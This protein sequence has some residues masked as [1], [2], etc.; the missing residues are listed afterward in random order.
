[1]SNTNNTTI[2]PIVATFFR[3]LCKALKNPSLALYYIKRKLIPSKK[4]IHLKSIFDCDFYQNNKDI[5]DYTKY[6]GL[7]IDE[8]KSKDLEYNVMAAYVKSGS[9]VIDI[10]ANIGF[11]T[12]GLSKL[13]GMSGFVYAFEPGPISFSI[14]SRNI[15]ANSQI[16]GDNVILNKMAISDR[17]GKSNLFINTSGE[18][19][20]Q[21][22]HDT[23]CY[24]FNSEPPR[25]KIITDVTTLDSYFKNYEKDKISFIKCD[26]QGHEYYVLLGSPNLFKRYRNAD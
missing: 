4:N 13:V 8:I 6:N 3:K 11:Y 23:N 26:A 22:H 10:G 21:I 17:D 9:T 12:L 18:S 7:K 1:M 2:S 14:L 5:I 15:Y 19:D 24:E 16:L 25:P 20:N